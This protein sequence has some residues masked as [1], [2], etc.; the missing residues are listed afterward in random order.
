MVLHCDIP[1]TMITNGYHHSLLF[2]INKSNQILI[3][4]ICSNKGGWADQPS[5]A[6]YP[7]GEGFRAFLQCSGIP[8]SIGPCESIQY[9]TILLQGI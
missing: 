2:N 8:K 1:V 3:S 9:N 6:K 7:K 4:R 5:S